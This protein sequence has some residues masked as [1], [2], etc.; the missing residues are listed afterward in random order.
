MS[1]AYARTLAL[2]TLL[3][4]VTLIPAAHAA[5]VT[6]YSDPAAFLAAIG[7]DY[8][9]VDFD[10]FASGTFITNQV[11]GV[12]FSSPLS[13]H[14]GFFPIQAFASPGSVSPPNSLAGGFVS[15]SP[16][17]AQ[18]IVLDFSPASS[19]FGFFLSPL[20]PNSII[21]SV[22]VDLA[23]DTTQTFPVSDGDSSGAEFLGLVSSAGITRITFDSENPQGG[24]SGFR[25]FGLDDMTFVTVDLNPPVCT[26]QKAIVDG[27]LGFNGTSTDNGPFDGGISSVTLV[28]ATNVTL[29]CDAPLPSACGSLGG[30]TPVAT[31]RIVPTIVQQNGQGRVVATD[32]G[33]NTCSISATFTAFGGGPVQALDVCHAPGISLEAS[34]PNSG[35]A[36]PIACGSSLPGPG[37]P[38]FPPGYEPSPAG[39]PSACTV[40]TIKSPISGLTG[41]VLDKD[42]AFEPRLRLLYSK[43]DGTTFP[44]F[45]DITQTILEIA[46]V[47]PDPT[48][49]GGT[50]TWSQ[51]KVAC[52]VLAEQCNGLDDDGDGQTDEGYPVGGP[53]RDCDGDGYPMCP[54]SETTAQ[55]CAGGTV[56]LAPGGE[57]DCNDQIPAIHAGAAERCNGLDDDCDDTI[58][59]DLGTT[60]CG[61]GACARTVDACVN[62]V[63]QACVPGTPGTETCNN[64]DDDCDGA[65]DD[66]FGT[67]SCGLGI[68]ART[69]D[70][71]VAGAPQT[72]VPG[73]PET[74]VCNGLDDD[75]DGATDEAYVFS[76]YLQPVNDD[77]TS[78]FQQKS[79]IPFKFRLNDCRGRNVTTAV[80]TIEILPFA[81]Q[82]VGTVLESTPANLKPSL[83]TQYVYDA[84]P[85]HYMFNFSTR[86]LAPNASYIA[87]TR[88][89][90]GTVHDVVFSLK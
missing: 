61:V 70:A 7:P 32:V 56:T 75:C 23:D 73:S 52:A 72:C 6:T 22:Q 88:I 64:I 44:P 41:M 68:C 40:S 27:V 19:A 51:V 29:T 20:T 11:P 74:E 53:A 42:G 43:F 39:D 79:T 85:G 57:V 83:G 50:G 58:D 35:P 24:Q 15:G 66:G 30:A 34:N 60:S 71:C 1:L 86:N 87:R 82:V 49:V 38:A 14:E 13:I 3:V 80:A 63:P 28:D 37:D 62:H 31:W 12:T 45:T 55:T 16:D 26:L 59:E 18:T 48:R 33:G 90:D 46:T 81:N 65:T 67:T 17:L 78:V 2:T 5:T 47:I 76:G 54:T 77:G 84:K 8:T 89:N 4:G 21:V 10:G 25:Q 69:V 9:E 36:G